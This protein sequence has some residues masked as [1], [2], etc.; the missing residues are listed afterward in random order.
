MIQNRIGPAIAQ[1]YWE[2]Y[3]KALEANS[4]QQP[5]ADDADSTPRHN[6]D[7]AALARENKLIDCLENAVYWQPNHR[8]RA[9]R[10]GRS[11]SALVRRL[12]GELAQSDDADK[13]PRRRNRFGFFLAASPARLACRRSGRELGA[14]G[15]RLASYP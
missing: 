3:L 6:A 7:N 14:F 9:S 5:T 2:Q 4:P 12:A 8:V 15:R 10:L 1:P 13:Y 11:P